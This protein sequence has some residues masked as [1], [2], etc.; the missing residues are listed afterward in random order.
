MAE[1]EKMRAI[2]KEQGLTLLSAYEDKTSWWMTVAPSICGTAWHLRLYFF[3]EADGIFRKASHTTGAVLT[4]KEIS[5]I[6][7]VA[8]LLDTLEKVRL[9][10]SNG[11]DFADIILD[12]VDPALAALRGEPNA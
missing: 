5:R 1:R 6:P 4:D 3:D 11:E 8:R 10:H 7:P 12:E 9:A 2:A